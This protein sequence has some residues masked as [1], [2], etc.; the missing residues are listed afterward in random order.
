[1]Q[2]RSSGHSRKS[3][4]RSYYSSES[5]GG[6]VINSASD[7]QGRG[8]DGLTLSSAA[9]RQ[10]TMEFSYR[11]FSFHSNSPAS[12][13]RASQEI[14]V[15]SHAPLSWV[16]GRQSPEPL[17]L[18]QPTVSSSFKV[19]QLS[20]LRLAA[21]TFES[22]Q[23]SERIETLDDEVTAET[24]PQ[25]PSSL[26]TPARDYLSVSPSAAGGRVE[27]LTAIAT[28]TARAT[29]S[30]SSSL[31]TSFPAVPSQGRLQSPRKS[32]TG[33]PA[34]YGTI[35]ESTKVPIK[36][37]NTGSEDD[38]LHHHT[39]GESSA[40]FEHQRQ[41]NHQ[42]LT[43]RKRGQ[44]DE[45]LRGPLNTADLDGRGGLVEDDESAP[46]LGTGTGVSQPELPR[47]PFL[48]TIKGFLYKARRS[49]GQPTYETQTTRSF[50][51]DCLYAGVSAIP[52]VI[53]GLILNL[54]DALSYGII[55][56]PTS[57]E[58]FPPSAAQA[59]ISMFLASTII[60]QVVFA[61]GGSGFKG[62][63]GSMMIEVSMT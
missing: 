46:L 1:M 35:G 45:Q 34:G 60:S 27:Q 14:L 7:S 9:I 30:T 57:N 26:L 43:S 50:V 13:K 62:A 8:D 53:L 41:Q 25:I 56:F 31:M 63:N 23:A 40:S 33:A 55:I 19:S 48:D 11:E 36:F 42:P 17:P 18:H 54:L 6:V 58:L 44:H 2:R 22:F 49:E 12:M 21:T 20:A 32:T 52:A 16:P 47:V 39:S 15:A 29:S 3:I 24:S 61:L 5:G 4:S 51:Y 10:Q 28:T 38:T 59:G 37:D